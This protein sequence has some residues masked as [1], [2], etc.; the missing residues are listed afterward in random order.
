MWWIWYYWIC[1]IAWTVYGL[2]VSQ[3]GDMED[4]I[5]VPGT[6]VR[7]MIKTYIQEHFGYNT[8][9]MGPVV[10]VLVGFTLLFAFMYA[11]GIKKLNFQN[12]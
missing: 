9:F 2:I 10:A 11:Y 4:T 7:P 1:P 3:Y 12:R 6:L 5:K 8:D